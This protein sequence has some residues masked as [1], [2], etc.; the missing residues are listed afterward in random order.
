MQK[1][2]N[3]KITFD[4]QTF[5]SQREARRFW[6]LQMLERA[7]EITGLECQTPFELIPAQRT[8]AGR[9]E[10]GVTYIADF[11]YW[12]DGRLVIEDVKGVRTKEYIIK[13]KL[14]LWK[15]GIEIKEV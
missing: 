5:D 7:G 1:Y 10:R 14:M 11:V 8:S 4:G 9:L 2:H 15:Y 13:R 12:Q 6:E 3:R